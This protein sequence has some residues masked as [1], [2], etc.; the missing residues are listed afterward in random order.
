MR[1]IAGTYKS[2]LLAAPRGLSVRPT[3]DRARESLFAVLGEEVREGPFLDLFAGTGAVGL[4]ALSRGAPAAIF[5]E[6]DRAALAALRRN[7]GS[8]H[9]EDLCRILPLDWRAALSRLAAE[10]ADFTAVFAD[11]PYDGGLA[12]AS[13]LSED[14][15]AILRPGG[16][17]VVEHRRKS[18]LPDP[19]GHLSP[20]RRLEAGEAVFSIYRKGEKD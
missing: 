5:V 14:L 20:A 10:G 16:I 11:P 2:R 6:R 17:L 15:G 1:V 8:L 3:G 13:L 9:A 4:E 12:A 19:P 18:T 7:V